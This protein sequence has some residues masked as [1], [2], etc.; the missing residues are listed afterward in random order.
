MKFE[1]GR[2]KTGGRQPGTA[3]KTTLMIKD[4]ALGLVQDPQYLASL[5]KRM[6][7]GRSPQLEIL[8]H[9]YAYG[10]PKIEISHDKNVT[11]IVRRDQRDAGSLLDTKATPAGYVT[12]GREEQ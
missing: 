10:K 3:N 9:Y 5:K 4:L 7:S 11:V 8:M 1:K 12:D 2:Q 6:E